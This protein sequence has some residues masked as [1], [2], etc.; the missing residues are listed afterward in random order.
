MKL[1][2]SNYI[3]TVR[4]CVVEKT[5]C[6]GKLLDLYTLLTL[7]TGENTTAKNVH[8]A[9]AI[10]CKNPNHK[11]LIP[12]EEL[13]TEVQQLDDFYVDAIKEVAYTLKE[14]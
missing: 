8:D 10:A 5:K 11:S 6:Q 2:T 1:T 9:W 13:S 14:K 4:G 7:T 12:F 3:D